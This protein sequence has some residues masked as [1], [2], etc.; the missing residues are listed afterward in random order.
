MRD[1]EYQGGFSLVEVLV[2]IILVGLAVACLVASNSS[3]TQSNAAGTELSTAEFLSEQIKELTM[4]LPVVD[5]EPEMSTFGPE[6]DEAGLADYD[7]LD[8]FDGAVFSPPINS[9][10]L[11]LNDFAAYSQQ[12]TVENVSAANFEQVVADHGSYFVRV[13]VKVFLNSRQI[14]SADWVR[15]WY[16]E[17]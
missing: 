5:P 3:F 2:A 11:V 13:T 4:L 8:D 7:D 14:S 10:R 6:T 17:Q 16:E 15:A 1:T 12:V 9:E